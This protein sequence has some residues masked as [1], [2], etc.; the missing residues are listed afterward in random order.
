MTAWAALAYALGIIAIV[1]S[2]W[3]HR[4]PAIDPELAQA[5]IVLPDGSIPVI[6]LGD[7]G[8]EMPGHQGDRCDFCLVASGSAPAPDGPCIVHP[9]PLHADMAINVASVATAQ[10]A[11]RSTSPR[12]PPLA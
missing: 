7:D 12:G 2:S 10:P 3:A 5:R 11:T 4:P 1:M 8:G 6:C 9:L